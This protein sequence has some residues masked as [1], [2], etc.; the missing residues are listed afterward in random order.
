MSEEKL[1]L[2]FDIPLEQLEEIVGVS[3]NSDFN[4]YDRVI[5]PR[6]LVA[7]KGITFFRKKVLDSLIR[8]IPLRSEG[9][10]RIYLYERAQIRVFGREPKGTEVGQ[11]F[12]LERKVMSILE[13]LE[14]GIF[15]E[16]VVKGVSKMP[17]AQIYGSDSEGK[18]AIAFYIPPFVEVH[19][20][21]AVIVDGIHRSYICGGAETT[22]NA[23]HI[24]GVEIPLPFDPLSWEETKVVKEKP[25]IEERYKNLKRE[26][27]RDLGAVGIDG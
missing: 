21:N 9:K 4:G 2:K 5:S 3:I 7:V 11:T 25:P 14:R 10:D 27:F 23:V 16:F 15:G 6:D 1:N 17:P 22:I 26:F 24:Y 20:N 13:G 19:G 18:K 12:I 8:R